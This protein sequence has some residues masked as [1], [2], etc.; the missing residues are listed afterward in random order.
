MKLSK[1]DINPNNNT[2]INIYSDNNESFLD[3]KRKRQ[4]SIHE[5]KDD[6]KKL[7]NDILDISQKIS[8]LNNDVIKI[9]AETSESCEDSENIEAIINCSNDELATVYLSENIVQQIIIPKSNKII[10][11]EKEILVHLKKIKIYLNEMLNKLSK[12]K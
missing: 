2:K 1:N 7:F 4:N 11:E 9:N 8:N 6:T 10:T 3:N 12:T 5:N